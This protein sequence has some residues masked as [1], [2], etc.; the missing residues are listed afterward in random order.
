MNT[1][2]KYPGSKWSMTDWIISNFPADYEKMTYLEPYA[3]SL[4]VFFNKKRSQ[5]ETINDLDNNI[6]NLFEVIREQPEEFKRAI[7]YTPWARQEYKNSYEMTGDSLEDARRFLVRCWQAI[8][9][10]TSDISGWS[11]HIKPGDT[12]TSRWT[13]LDKS[14][15]EAAKRLQSYKKCLVQIENM[16][17]VDLIRRYNR[18][19]VFI[20]CD[21][22]Y[23]LSTRSK[24]IYK[25]EMTDNDHIELLEALTGHTGPV[26]ISGYMNEIYNEMLKGWTVKTNKSNCEMGKAA[27]EVIWMNY[28]P[29]NEQLSLS[30]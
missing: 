16:P 4:A 10:K 13:R 23:V 25:C 15:D 5:I 12:G 14:I 6:T 2:L 29:S 21:P 8:G 24:R 18:P 22:P 17:A 11:N 20:Y 27:T 28:K 1:V 7:K 9:T 26:M 3:G 30:I 19:Y